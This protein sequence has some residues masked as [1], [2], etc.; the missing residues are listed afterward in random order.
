MREATCGI[1][2]AGGR[3]TRLAGAVPPAGKAALA[4]GGRP[5]IGRILTTLDA[6]VSRRIVVAAAR[7]PLP[8]LPADVRVVRDTRAGAGPLAALADGLEWLRRDAAGPAVSAVVVLSCDVPL[9]TPEV[10]RMLL[11]RLGS[12][13]GKAGPVWVVPEVGGHLQVLVSVLRPGLLP[14]MEDHLAAGRRDPRSLVDR[15]RR[16]A[17]WSVAIVTEADV[18][19]VDP[20]LTSF[21]D[22]D[23]PGDLEELRRIAAEQPPT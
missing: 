6:V 17:P 3:S 11:Q 13:H 2:L 1:V 10:L 7:Q 9:V 15:L 20:A 14:S 19:R 4:I 22:V 5:L 21:R 23:T 12:A 16:D 18:R 8:D